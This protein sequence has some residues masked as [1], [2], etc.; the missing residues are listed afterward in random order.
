MSNEEQFEYAVKLI[1]LG[2][3]H[4]F[5][6]STITADLQIT[7][8]SALILTALCES[9]R[10]RDLA[11]DKRSIDQTKISSYIGKVATY[12]M[13]V[14][15][16]SKWNGYIFNTLDDLLKRTEHCRLVPD[17][18]YLVSRDILYPDKADALINQYT[19]AAKFLE[20]LI[21]L[22]DF[23]GSSEISFLIPDRVDIACEYAV[24]DI[25]GADFSKVDVICDEL[26]PDK[27]D[28]HSERRR[29]IFISTFVS[30]VKNL[31]QAERLKNIFRQL[32]DI[33][34][35]YRCDYTLY[36]QDF[37]FNK[38]VAEIDE[39]KSEQMKRLNAV[40]Q[41]MSIRLFAIPIAY[42]L[43]AGQLVENDGMKNNIIM[44]GA[45]IFAFLMLL[46]V[47]SQLITLKHI[48]HDRT[49][50]ESDYKDKVDNDV[51]T[52]PLQ[53]LRTKY[54]LQMG[55]LISVLLVVVG[56]FYMSF[57]LYVDYSSPE[58]VNSIANYFNS[59]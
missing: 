42:I 26:F 6:G 34:S 44:T 45:A 41:D 29:E 38:L 54:Y 50:L 1:R 21:K 15:S 33:Y 57:E 8:E 48:K 58:W 53:Q 43:I 46:M 28:H 2:D 30:T 55:I 23:E 11:V 52:I 36:A 47:I 9:H 35:R 5:D 59:E 27:P 16:G 13:S 24:S 25:Q 7:E 14:P 39:K 56:I 22:A 49:V 37:S 19:S 3:T 18:F 31:P 4:E 32:N 51:L 40:V 10:V 17:R 20:F 12:E